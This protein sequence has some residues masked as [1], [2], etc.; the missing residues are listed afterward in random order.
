MQNHNKQDSLKVNIIKPDKQVTAVS[1]KIVGT[2]DKN[3]FCLYD[4]KRHAVG[5]KIINMDGSESV[6]SEDS[7]WK[8]N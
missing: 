6:C 8:N 5:S 7:S 1:D 2:A 4:H 3:Q